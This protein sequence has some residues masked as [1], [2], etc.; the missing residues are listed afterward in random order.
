MCD[1]WYDD[2]PG[3]IS[4]TETEDQAFFNAVHATRPVAKGSEVVINWVP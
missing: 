4:F 2:G 1:L 3:G